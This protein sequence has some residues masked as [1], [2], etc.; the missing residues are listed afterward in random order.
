[1]FIP[2]LLGSEK[3][4]PHGNKISK[5]LT[6]YNINNAIRISSAHKS[7]RDVLDIIRSCEEDDE[8]PLV[9]TAVGKSNALSGVVDSNFNKPVICCPLVTN[10]TMYDIFSSLSMP[11]DVAVMVVLSPLNA[12]LA[13]VKICGLLDYSVRNK[14][15]KLHE[16]NKMKLKLSDLNIKYVNIF[17]TTPTIKYDISFGEPLKSGKIRDI[18]I[19]IKNL[20]IITSDR[21]SCFDRI[22]ANVKYKGYILNNI[23]GFWFDLTKDIVPNHMISYSNNSMIVKTCIPIKL[24]FV[25]RDYLTGSTKTSIYTN[26]A[27][28]NRK[29]CGHVLK[30]GMVRNQKLP[31]TLLTPTTKGETD[32]LIDKDE[33]L[34]R[35][36]LSEEEWGVCN[37]YAH[38]LFKIGSE[39]ASKR[40]LILVDTKYEFGRTEEGKIVL[41]D[42]LHTPDS[43]RYWIKYNYEEKFKNSQEPDIIDK[44]FVRKWIKNT[45]KDPYDKSTE[46]IIPE[47]ILDQL[48]IKYFQLYEILLGKE[49]KL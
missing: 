45:Y 31:E 14:I 44:D 21:L 8:I 23:S 39:E 26:Y 37:L 4:L 10:E 16:S 20:K 46:I 41:I 7:T 15:T 22:L 27:N 34:K 3:D 17:D 13:A 30:D 2:I 6:E 1:M 36:I 32:E 38:T 42:E 18:F 33:I 29:Y 11:R 43:S 24:E 19:H 9:I 35:G 49:F 12:A 47:E 40:G 25:V 28:G 48:S 5:T